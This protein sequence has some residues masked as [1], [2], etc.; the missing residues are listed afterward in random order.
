MG[1]GAG[2]NLA[3]FATATVYEID[4]N[5]MPGLLL[6]EPF[7]ACAVL[8]CPGKKY[9]LSRMLLEQTHVCWLEV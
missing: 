9:V 3:A 4:S 2:I 8:T 7:A 5:I 1:D 6:G